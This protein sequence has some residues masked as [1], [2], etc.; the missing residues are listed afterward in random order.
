MNLRSVLGPRGRDLGRSRWPFTT[1]AAIVAAAL[2]ALAGDWIWA[3]ALGALAVVLA[4]MT[5][6]STGR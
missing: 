4:V 2:F 5:V 3:F 6:R 1:V